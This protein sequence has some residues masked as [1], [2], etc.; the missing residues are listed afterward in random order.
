MIIILS[1]VQNILSIN[2]THHGR[3][4]HQLRLSLDLWHFIGF[5]SSLFFGVWTDG[6]KLKSCTI[7]SEPEL[8]LFL[9]LTHNYVILLFIECSSHM[10]A[11]P[12]LLSAGLRHCYGLSYSHVCTSYQ[13]RLGD[14]SVNENL[15]T[16]SVKQGRCVVFSW[17]KS[18]KCYLN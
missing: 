11:P 1:S 16:R 14:A 12:T 18:K 8:C 15:F 6:Y 9:L 5:P 17:E 13:C 10:P 4:R 7:M 3:N 2:L